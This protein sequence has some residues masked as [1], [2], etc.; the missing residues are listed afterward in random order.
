MDKIKLLNTLRKNI[1][2]IQNKILFNIEKIKKI[3]SKTAREISS[4]RK[5]EQVVQWKIKEMLEKRLKELEDLHKSPYFMKC[6]IKELDK[7]TTKFIYFSKFELIDESISSWLSPI[8]SIRFENPGLVTY[9]L[10]SNAVKK[11]ELISKEQYMIVDGQ[12]IFFA[13]ESKTIPRTLIYQKHFSNKKHTFFL[14]EI[15]TQM[16]KAQDYVIR[17]P[18]NEPMIISGPAGSGKTTLAFHRLAYL[19]RSPDTSSYFPSEDVMVFVQDSGTRN[20]FVNL[21]PEL[22]I[23]NVRITTFAEWVFNLLNLEGYEYVSRYGNYEQERDEYEYQKL[24]VLRSV[25]NVKFN[26]NL[27]KFLKLVYKD[28]FTHGCNKLF[29]KQMEEK[30]LDRFDLTIFIR[31]FLNSSNIKKT[32]YKKRIVK[33]AALIIDEFQ[34]YLPEQLDV[35]KMFIDNNHNSIIYVGDI[36][37][38]IFIGTT[39]TQEQLNN[40]VKD[41]RQIVMS[42]VY[43]NTKKILQFIQDCG[44]EI[45]IPEGIKEGKGVIEKIVSGVE[46]EI[47]YIKEQINFNGDNTIGILTKDPNYLVRFKEEFDGLENIHILTMIES[48]GVE[49]DIVFIVGINKEKFKLDY[50]PENHLK[51]KNKIE[52]DI[53]YIALTRAV[54]ELHILGIDKL[55]N[56]IDL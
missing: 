5:E 1:T 53:L 4:L 23:N 33:F 39:K 22:G 49:F 15:I 3:N 28:Y 9:N 48:Q 27:P 40:E 34:N 36:A 2:Y 25:K 18:Y 51:E 45:S 21:L 55:K 16:E 56:I 54:S 20:Y 12:V 37:Q 8:A 26:S 19:I 17:L 46:D 14:P 41:S 35:L 44:Y 24:Q 7:N 50:V 29:K 30:M 31:S 42:K 32:S 6:K 10:P 11:I 43:R 52:K 47:I 13:L 38:Q